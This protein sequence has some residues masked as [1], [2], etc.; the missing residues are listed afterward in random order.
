[1]ENIKEVNQK[2][3]KISRIVNQAPTPRL[4]NDRIQAQWASNFPS[5]NIWKGYDGANIPIWNL[6]IEPFIV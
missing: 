3:G 4:E 6:E 1:M 2:P 5:N